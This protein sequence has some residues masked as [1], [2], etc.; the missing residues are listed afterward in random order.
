MTVDTINANIIKVNTL[1]VAGKA[2]QG[3][4]GINDGVSGVSIGLPDSSGVSVSN[5]ID[6]IPNHIAKT[7]IEGGTVFTN[8]TYVP[9]Y[10]DLA[11]VVASGP[12]ASYIE[13]MQSQTIAVP[14]NPVTTPTTIVGAVMGGAPLLAHTFKTYNFS[15]TKAFNI[16]SEFNSVGNFDADSTTGFALVCVQTDD[17]TNFGSSNPADYMFTVG[18]KTIGDG[19]QNYSLSNLTTLEGNKDYTVWLFGLFNDVEADTAIG[20]GINNANITVQ[21]LNI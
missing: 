14:S 5:F 7:E 4:V 18:T 15:G 11:D 8:I 10:P 20:R 3:S 9:M 21:G 13:Y 19:Q 12:N 2:Y 6:Q 17:V 16:K 1:D